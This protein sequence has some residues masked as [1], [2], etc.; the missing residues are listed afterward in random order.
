[1]EAQKNQIEGYSTK[2][3][4]GNLDSL[5]K[6]LRE[7]KN[8]EIIA[9]EELNEA[10]KQNAQVQEEAAIQKQMR[11]RKAAEAFVAA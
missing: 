2:D 1:M 5:E 7:L 3:S 9:T 11:D 10:T 8:E 4:I 6:K